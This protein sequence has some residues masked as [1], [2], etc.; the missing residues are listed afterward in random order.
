M[1]KNLPSFN[2]ITPASHQ[3]GAVLIVSLML[4]VVLTMLGISAI[5]STKLET[6][7]AA[8]TIEYNRAFQTAEG[9]AA[10]AIDNYM[11]NSELINN[12]TNESSY[13]PIPESKTTL[14]GEKGIS[15]A[16]PEV[17]RSATVTQAPPGYGSDVQQNYYIVRS[18][19]WSRANEQQD[20][21]GNSEIVIDEENSLQSRIV[22]GMSIIGP[23]DTGGNI[24]TSLP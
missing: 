2:N 6:R 24:E 21:A 3:E 7:M 22:V 18:T 13:Q 1:N 8:N 9:G 11:K 19:G 14:K 4:L 15:V 10:K 5:E 17:R 12:I 20:N 16:I 23:S